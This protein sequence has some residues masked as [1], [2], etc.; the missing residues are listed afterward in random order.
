MFGNEMPV[1]IIPFPIFHIVNPSSQLQQ[2]FLCNE[3]S[4]DTHLL[5]CWGGLYIGGDILYFVNTLVK[6]FPSCHLCS[7]SRNMMIMM[8]TK[9]L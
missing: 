8:N 3:I 7:R 2:F 9:G 5:L 6:V 4:R 1:S